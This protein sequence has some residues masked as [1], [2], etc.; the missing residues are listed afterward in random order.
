[1][2]A[3]K[4]IVL[5]SLF[6]LFLAP[7]SCWSEADVKTI[8]AVR[9]NPSPN[10]DGLLNDPIWKVAPKSGEFT[11]DEPE[12][13]AAPTQSTT[14]QVAYDDEAV[15]FGL[16][17]YDSEPDKIVAKLTRRDRSI[18]SDDVRVGIDSY[19]DHLTGFYFNTN[20][21][22]VQQDGYIYKDTW[23]DD[24]WDGV[25]ESEVQIGKQGWTAEFKIPYSCLRFA[26]ADS[27]VWGVNFARWISRKSEYDLWVYVPEEEG[28]FV[29]RFGH[30]VGLKNIDPP[31]M[32]EFL[33]YAVSWENTEPER[34][35]N[36]DG[37]DFFSNLGVDVKYGLSSDLTLDATFNPDFGQVE[38]DATVLNLST[39][40]TYYDEKRPFFL[41]GMTIFDTPFELFYSRRIGKKPCADL[42]NDADYI[43]DQPATTTILSAMKLS[44]RT[45]GGTS[46]GIMNAV[47]QEERAT[48]RDT[49][50]IKRETLIEPS[51]NYSVVRLKQDIFGNSEVGLTTTAVNQRH[52]IPAYS[53]GLDWDIHFPKGIWLARGQ[54]VASR[55]GPD[56]HGGGFWAEMEK[57]AGKRVRGSLWWEYESRNFDINRLGFIGRGNYN[58]GGT[59]WQYRTYK[60]WHFIRETYHNVNYWNA[61][62][63]D[64]YKISHGGNYN[65]SI[66]T[67]SNWWFGG[68]Y[69]FQ[70]PY[71]DDRETRGG[72]PYKRPRGWDVWLW[73][74][75]DTRKWWVVDLFHGV[76]TNWDGI[77]E[78]YSAELQ[79]Q[80]RSNLEFSIG[81]SYDA[82]WHVSRWVDT[83]EDSS[84][85]EQYVF[86]ELN[87]KEIDINFRSTLTFTKNLSLQ[88]WVQAFMAIGDYENFKLLDPPGSFKP[89]GNVEYSGNLSH[90]T[91]EDDPDFNC[92]SLNANLV[93]RWEYRPGSTIYL[94]WTQFRDDY[95]E[96]GHLP[97]DEGLREIWNLSANNTFLIKA[98]Y[99]WSL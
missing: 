40:E 53:G 15:Y 82:H 93:L 86:G 74:D 16:T 18:E 17:M 14:V 19:H 85:N 95:E 29:S 51:A 68:G 96:Y 20:A 7:P 38:S 49:L 71:Y 6:L 76:G 77:Y 4:A 3:K 58:G 66:M 99:W 97:F 94:V 69:G 63:L 92:K 36:P 44:G 27:M 37:R 41:E 78:S 87:S 70:I 11:Q 67:T 89:L 47:T 13:G 57:E 45:K 43:I 81:P 64:G 98:N 79:I 73:V 59:W 23:T 65:N 39:F 84:G 22:G 28:G 42:G 50:D 24:S 21:A 54:V 25:W 33:P 31:R 61:W 26:K 35:G 46:I 8:T 91:Y 72:P 5:F 9:C 48:Y 80:P 10:I 90:N 2:T 60:D 55:T 34:P 30:L 1:M 62:N 56:E 88:V 32:M 75:S 83:V 52:E 12:E